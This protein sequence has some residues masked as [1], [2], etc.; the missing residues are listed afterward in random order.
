[1]ENIRIALVED[2]HLLRQSL[3]A[4]FSTVEGMT[5]VISAADGRSLLHLLNNTH[6]LP[7]IVIM[8][9]NLPELTGIEINELLRKQYPS[10]KV[11]VLSVHTQERLISKMINAGAC[12]YLSK[13]CES[14]EL[15]DAIKGVYQTGFYIN[16]GTLM[17]LQK[18]AAYR[19]KKVK[20]IDAAP[21]ELSGREREILELICKE[22]SNAEIAE[23]LSL[24]IRTI[25]GH[26]NNLLIKTSC[27]NTAGLVLFAI[28]YG[29]FEVL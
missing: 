12:A 9:M 4:L 23:K 5:L 18:A 28:R 16:G 7:D 19:N 11:I 22:L 1:M 25:E 24:S 27:R 20:N 15:I 13:S 6:P 17:A 26:R 14:A 3:S 2:Q 8:D 29:F 21:V 10:I